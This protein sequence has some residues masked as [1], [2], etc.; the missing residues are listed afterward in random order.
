MDAAFLGQ[1]SYLD[2]IVVQNRGL[3]VSRRCT[4]QDDVNMHELWRYPLT[5]RTTEMLDLNK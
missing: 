2:P 1:P 4:L 3:R 5:I